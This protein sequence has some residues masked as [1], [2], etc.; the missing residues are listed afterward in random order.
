LISRGVRTLEGTD[1]DAWQAVKAHAHDARARR[2]WRPAPVL[3]GLLLF[4]NVKL[5]FL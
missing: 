1:G 2:H 3:F 4:K 5:K